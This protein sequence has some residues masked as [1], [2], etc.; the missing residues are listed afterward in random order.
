MSK[1]IRASHALGAGH[2]DG[3]EEETGQTAGQKQK[4][5]PHVQGLRLMVTGG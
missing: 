1:L 4:I 3:H 2:G 5:D